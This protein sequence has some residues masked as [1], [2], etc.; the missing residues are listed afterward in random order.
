MKKIVSHSLLLVTVF[1]AACQ[2]PMEHTHCDNTVVS[3]VKSPDGAYLATVYHRSCAGGS[4][5]Y[6]CAK[7]EEIPPHFWS[8]SGDVGHILII[9]EFHPISAMWSDRRHLVIATPGLPNVPDSSPPPDMLSDRPK[10][11]W[12][13]IEVSYHR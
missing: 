2:D 1:A 13:D 12:R 10:K 5:R 11:T 4:G 9:S 3:Q 6:T 8:S 7:I